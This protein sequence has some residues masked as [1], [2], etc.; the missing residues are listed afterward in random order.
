MSI[1]AKSIQEKLEEAIRNHSTFKSEDKDRFLE[2]IT[3]VLKNIVNESGI[4]NDLNELYATNRRKYD[5]IIGNAFKM[6][7]E[8]YSKVLNDLYVYSHGLKN[9]NV[10]TDIGFFK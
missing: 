8:N 9:K 6:L 3:S 2:I 4:L 7:C 1:D 5:I 10:N